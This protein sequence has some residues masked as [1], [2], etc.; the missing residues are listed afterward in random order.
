MNTAWIG[1]MKLCPAL[2][3]L[4]NISKNSLIWFV[5]CGRSPEVFYLRYEI[6]FIYFF[7][8]FILGEYKL[9]HKLLSFS[10]YHRRC[11]AAGCCR[12]ATT[13]Q[14][15]SVTITECSFRSCERPIIRC[16]WS[17]N[18][19]EWQQQRWWPGDW[20]PSESTA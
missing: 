17:A 9:Y 8:Q 13:G 6:S 12:T 19:D 7:F 20:Q 16:I 14:Q 1:S 4:S 18:R 3:M 2:F 15:F 11:K 10:S 5:L